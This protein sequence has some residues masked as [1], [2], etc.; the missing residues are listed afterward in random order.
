MRERA[1]R[2]KGSLVRNGNYPLDA[3]NFT[4][5]ERLKTLAISF[6]EASE[7]KNEDQTK[8]K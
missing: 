2:F 4:V 7:E 8:D 3:I 1:N 6:K 5:N